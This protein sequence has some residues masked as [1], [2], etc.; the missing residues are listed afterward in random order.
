ML[1]D[2]SADVRVVLHDEHARLTHGFPPASLHPSI[3]VLPQY[4]E[5]S[6]ASEKTP[7]NAKN[8]QRALTVRDS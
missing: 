2:D 5:N 4:N 6:A 8:A 3:A 1:R 7:S